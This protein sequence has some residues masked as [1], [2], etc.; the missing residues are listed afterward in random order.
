[1][2]GVHMANSPGT[3]RDGV[4]GG[5]ILSHDHGTILMLGLIVQC[6]RHSTNAGLGLN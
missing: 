6:F 1:M 5:Y 2:G 4:G 3:N